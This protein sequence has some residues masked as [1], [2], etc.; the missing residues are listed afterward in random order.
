MATLTEFS[1]WKCYECGLFNHHSRTYC[2]AC[3]TPARH[4]SPLQSINNKQ[5]VLFHGFLRF[6]ILCHLNTNQIPSD[7]I[8]LGYKFYQIDVKSLSDTES[9]L[10]KAGP[11]TEARD[12]FV[13]YEL[14]NLVKSERTDGYCYYAMA[15]ICYQ[16]KEY[17][18]CQSLLEIS[19]KK[20][21]YSRKYR[22]YYH[23]GLTLQAQK[24]HDL[25][26]THFIKSYNRHSSARSALE[27]GYSYHQLKNYKQ[28]E[29]Y[30]L[31]AINFDAKKSRYHYYYGCLLK[32]MKNYT[33]AVTEFD[34]AIN[35]NTRTSEQWMI[36]R[37]LLHS[38]SC[39][40]ELGDSR[41]ASRLL[42]ECK[43]KPNSA[44]CCLQI[45]NFYKECK[46]MDNA[47]L[48]H[49]RAIEVDNGQNS[50]YCNHYGLFLNSIV[51]DYEAAKVYFLKAI[52]IN[53]KNFN[54][55]YN[56]AV[57]L[58][59]NIKDYKESE[60]YYLMGLELNDK[61]YNGSYGYLLYLM[62]RYQDSLKYIVKGIELEEDNYFTHYYHALIN[63]VFGKSGE[64]N[65]SILRSVSLIT[66]QNGDA[67]LKHL[68]TMENCNPLSTELHQRFKKYDSIET[69]VL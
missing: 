21:P 29:Q 17:E 31:K 52:E 38:A 33:K 3:F 18:H 28:A 39:Y 9:I 36:T 69:G 40:H 64:A 25:A 12:Y 30:Y 2:Q 68:N 26:L 32:E 22:D 13:A 19:I 46:D 53:P 62:G 16:W 57:T 20:A 44:E 59:D 66:S 24:K 27:V 63:N 61:C 42:D 60:K 58:R 8:N 5:V 43:A 11:C 34:A 67:V 10:A 51:G 65:L 6:K 14:Y 55:Y 4:L 7:I 49:L 15:K 50:K 48:Y 54:L 41:N 47:Q 37:S 45:A 1:L 56:V 23:L 35:G